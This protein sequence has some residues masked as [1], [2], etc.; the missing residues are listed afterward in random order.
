MKH[1]KN[2]ISDYIESKAYEWFGLDFTSITVINVGLPFEDF[3]DSIYDSLRQMI[4]KV[5]ML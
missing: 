5:G 3:F 4:A 1:V 2:I